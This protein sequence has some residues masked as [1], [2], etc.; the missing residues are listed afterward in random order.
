MLYP[1]RKEFGEEVIVNR[2]VEEIRVARESVLRD[3][4]A[5]E[6]ALDAGVVS[7]RCRSIAAHRSAAFTCRKLLQRFTTGWTASGFFSLF[8]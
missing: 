4:L 1:R 8:R 5:F 3:V 6:S 2:G 7:R